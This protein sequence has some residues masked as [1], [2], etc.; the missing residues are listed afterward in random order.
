MNSSCIKYRDNE[1]L[2][3][4]LETNNDNI[5]INWNEDDTLCAD[6]LSS[7]TLNEFLLEAEKKTKFYAQKNYNHYKLIGNGYSKFN[8]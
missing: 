5:E 2:G 7:I 6:K 3:S 4:M 8:Y 1:L